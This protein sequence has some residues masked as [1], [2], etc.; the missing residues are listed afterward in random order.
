[1]ASGVLGIAI[2]SSTIP[3]LENYLRHLNPSNRPDDKFFRELWENVFGCSPASTPFSTSPPSNRVLQEALLPPCNGTESLEGIQH[4][5]T[6]T[7]QLRV[8][9][10]VYLAVYA[11][12]HALH[13]LLC[14]NRDS[15]SGNTSSTCS[16]PKD[17]KPIEVNNR[18]TATHKMHCRFSQPMIAHL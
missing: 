16:F 1:M 17:I 8:T 7:S 12:A 11:V 10:N 4:P 2:R 15:P 3:G 5:F 6:Y 13:N 9:Y 14:P 18:S